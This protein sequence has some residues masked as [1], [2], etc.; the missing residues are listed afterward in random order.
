MTEMDDCYLSQEP[1]CCSLSHSVVVTKKLH[2]QKQWIHSGKPESV[3]CL[4]KKW[5]LPAGSSLESAR[6]YQTSITW[7]RVKTNVR[8]HGKRRKGGG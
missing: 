4:D 3:F 1:P 8:L 6:S 5:I 7:Q 2:R